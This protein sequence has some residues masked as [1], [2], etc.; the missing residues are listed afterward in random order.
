MYTPPRFRET[1]EAFTL[2]FVA[3]NGFATLVSVGEDGPVATHVPIDLH[4]DWVGDSVSSRPHGSR[5]PAVAYAFARARR[6]HDLPRAARLR[7]ASLVRPSER[8]DVELPRRARLRSSDGPDESRRAPAARARAGR[9]IRGG[10]ER[11]YR[12]ESLPPELLE[13]ELRGIV[14]FRIAITRIEANAKLSQN[15]G[16]RDYENVVAE[17]EKRGDSGSRGVAELMRRK[18]EPKK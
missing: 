13:R 10:P 7:L 5:Q 11:R 8:P 14:G 17:L 1:D 16:E 4:R 3:G 15:R 6:A 12:V 2:D 18:K 9:E